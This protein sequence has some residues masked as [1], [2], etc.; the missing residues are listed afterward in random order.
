MTSKTKFPVPP[1]FA[2]GGVAKIPKVM[3]EF[4]SGKLH[5]GSKSGPVV[6]SRDQAVAIAMSEAGKTKKR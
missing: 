4:S 2:K 1:G 5:S 3:G 6:K